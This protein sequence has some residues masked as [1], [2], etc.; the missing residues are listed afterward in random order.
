MRLFGSVARN[1]VF[2]EVLGGVRV[3]RAGRVVVGCGPGGPPGHF[4]VLLRAARGAQQAH[5][6]FVIRGF[7]DSRAPECAGGVSQGFFTFLVGT[8]LD[9]LQVGLRG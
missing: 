3:W 5:R 4:G 9:K 2:Y 8:S 7:W 6:T 1:P